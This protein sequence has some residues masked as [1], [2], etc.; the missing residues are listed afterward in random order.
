MSVRTVA[1]TA[2]A[3]IGSLDSPALRTSGY[4]TRVCEASSDPSS[5]AAAASHPSASPAI[6][7]NAIGNANVSRPK[8][9]AEV[10]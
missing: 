1:P 6:V 5:S 4:R 10:R 9:I 7:P 2:L 3:M 8:V